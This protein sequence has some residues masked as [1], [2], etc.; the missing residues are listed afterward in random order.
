MSE[1][2]DRTT[3]FYVGYL[4]MP[5]ALKRFN[6]LAVAVLLVAAGTL[7]FL[8]SAGM[9][10]AGTGQWDLS[11]P[12]TLE[13]RLVA[14]PYP[15]LK[16][17]GV[18]PRTVLLVGIGKIGAQ[19]W[20][21][22]HDGTSVRV[23]GFEIARGPWSI[24]ELE[25]AEAI[26]PAAIPVVLADGAPEPVGPVALQGEII[27]SKC[28]LGVMK[29]G[30]GRVHKACATVCLLGGMPPM[31]MVRNARGQRAAYLMTDPDGGPL[32]R[33]LAAYVADPVALAGTV[34]RR[35]DILVLKTDPASIRRL[36]GEELVAFGPTV[37]ADSGPVICTLPG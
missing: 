34:E 5:A 28:F 11:A 20:A 13:G 4:P 33:E 31:F 29:P 8:V 23:T 9:R 25:N 16:L 15:H 1:Q 12:V 21:A 14:A 35:G 32:R 19:A 2:D 22:P 37:R 27:D 6:R 36:Q 30:E 10:V 26:Q 24:L 7:A 18:E 3:P 17:A